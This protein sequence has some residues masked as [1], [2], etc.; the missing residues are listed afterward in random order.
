MKIQ[1]FSILAGS[2][3]CPARCPFCVSKMTPPQGMTIKEPEISSAAWKKFKKAAQLAKDCDSTT[4]LITGKGEPVLFPEQITKYLDALHEFRFPLIELQTSGIPLAEERYDRHLDTW[5]E[6]A[7]NTI[8]I[9]IVHY[10]PEK[11][12]SIYLPYRKSY[13]DL[14]DLTDKLHKKGFSLRFSCV[15]ADGYICSPTDIDNL[16]SYAKEHNIE[17][18]TLRPVN[19]PQ[20]S[21]DERASGWVEDHYL[22]D[23]QR[24]EIEKYLREN[25]HQLMRLVHGAT[26]YDVR[27]QNVC[28]TNSLTLAP[29]TDGI[30]QLIFFPDGHLRYD[31][32][33]EGAIL[34]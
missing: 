12:R 1:T 17:Q 9:S 29:S 23:E 24:A 27:G 21:N 22:H 33:Y 30:R 15:M 13:I 4:V 18:L 8:A 6:K 19:R 7:L 3:A 32:Q 20:N 10:D 2:E 25:G 26:V 28:Y 34:L 11:N 16:I 14:P 31:W 5:F